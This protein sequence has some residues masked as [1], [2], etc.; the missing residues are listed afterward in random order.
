MR[1]GFLSVLLENIDEGIIAC[2]NKGKP[3]LFNK[4]AKEMLG[5]T[6]QDIPVEK[7]ADY[8][9]FYLPDSS[10]PMTPEEVPFLRALKGESIKD[11]EMEIRPQDDEKVILLVNGRSFFNNKGKKLG[12]VVAMQDITK[13][14]KIKG[15]LETSLQRFEAIYNSQLDAIV[16]TD[17]DDCITEANSSMHNLFGYDP[18]ELIGRRL[19][20]LLAPDVSYEGVTKKIEAL[21]EPEP[22]GYELEFQ[23][24]NGEVFSGIIMAALLC[25]GDGNKQGH[26][27]MIRDQSETKQAEAELVEKQKQLAESREEERLRMARELH[28]GVIQD[29]LSLSYQFADDE[30]QV[31]V[32]PSKFRNELLKFVARLR[33]F[34][35]E[36]RPINLEELGLVPALEAYIDD[37]KTKKA[38]E[39]KIDLL[40]EEC[41]KLPNP[42]E[43]CI[44]RAVQELLNNVIKHARANWVKISL[45]CFENK[46][47]LLV[48]DNGYGFSPPENLADLSQQQHFGLVGLVERVELLDGMLGIRSKENEGTEVSI[49]LP[50]E[51]TN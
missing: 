43:L 2:N 8:Y 4:A 41:T 12:A 42:L 30:P 50:L 36:L 33:G 13:E 27:V 6:L 5:L 23:R 45:R 19:W 48:E 32:E 31:T 14:R 49:T 18:D 51:N 3:I 37:L 17:L 47:L 16:C 39:L 25:D 46:V 21:E 9:N 38:L 1:N 40:I 10:T 7:L 22:K 15:A 24:K 26:T 20:I 11:F 34:V 28:D 29:L 35:N 44:Y